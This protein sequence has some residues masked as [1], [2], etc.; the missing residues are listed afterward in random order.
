M[1][2]ATRQGRAWLRSRSNCLVTSKLIPSRF[3]VFFV[4]LPNKQETAQVFMNEQ[5]VLDAQLLTQALA[6][7]TAAFGDLYERYLDAIYHYVFYRVNGRQEA[8]DLTEGI[9]LRA[10]QALDSNPPRE[11]PFR[12]WLYRIAHNAV[13]DHYRTRQ[14]QVGL[15]AAAHLADPIEGPEAIVARQERA[16]ALKQAMLQLTEDHQE[17]LTCRFIV[18]L[19][20]AET[21]VVM[22]RNEEAVRALQYRAVGALRKLLISQGSSGYKSSYGYE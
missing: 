19:S 2:S 21:A 1:A 22:T 17:V 11:A 5:Q 13:V 15:E 4:L 10:W 12:L 20:H 14:E 8:E 6:G 9:F 7:D 18:G 3:L 16:N